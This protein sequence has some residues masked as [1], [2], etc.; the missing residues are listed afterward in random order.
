MTNKTCGECKHYKERFKFCRD[1]LYPLQRNSKACVNFEKE[2]I[3]NGDKI[4]AGG[5]RAIAE[6][7]QHISCTNCVYFSVQMPGLEFCHKPDDK[8]CTDGIEAW[9]NAPAESEGEDE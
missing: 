4:I 5:M 9:L 8:T 1:V 2:I 3:T 7:Q 6:F